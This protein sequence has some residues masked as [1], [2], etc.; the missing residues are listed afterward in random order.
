[1]YNFK[2]GTRYNVQFKGTALLGVGLKS[3]R[4]ISICDYR[5]ASLVGNVTNLHAGLIPYLEADTSHNAAELTYL[6]FETDSGNRAAYAYPWVVES[7]I[8]VA[9]NRVMTISI[10]GVTADD[11]VRVKEV[12]SLAGWKNISVNITG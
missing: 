2:V 1:M 6:I 8:E 5:M 12:L 11:A 10:P 7:S 4:L 3:A 9:E